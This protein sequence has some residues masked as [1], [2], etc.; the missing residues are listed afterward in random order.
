M[1]NMVVL[2]FAFAVLLSGPA[3]GQT[4]PISNPSMEA[5]SGS[6]AGWTPSDAGRTFWATTAHSGSRS[7]AVG[8]TGADSSVSWSLDR[9]QVDPGS[10]YRLSFWSKAE[11]AR[12]GGCIVSGLASANCDHLFSPVWRRYET[13]FRVP[14]TGTPVLRLGQW[15][16]TG[17]V[18]FDDVTLVRVT[19]AYRSFGAIE[20]GNGESVEGAK[21]A[22]E[23]PLWIGNAS[24]HPLVVCRAGFN[25]NRW[26]LTG[27]DRVVY[28]HA[29]AG[30]EQ[31]AGTLSVRLGYYT[32]GRCVVEASRDGVQWLLVCEIARKQTVRTALPAALF[33]AAEI[34]VRISCVNG[35]KSSGDSDPGSFQVN[36]YWYE[37]ALDRPV[38]GPV[39][40]GGTSNVELAAVSA[41][42][43]VEQPDLGQVTIG[44][45]S[46]MTFIIAN[47]GKSAVRG[48]ASLLLASDAGEP[49]HFGADFV[50]APGKTTVKVP[51]EFA[52]LHAGQFQASAVV[53]IGGIE[54]YR[55]NFPVDISV[56]EAADY[57]SR[58]S[59]TGSDDI[60][61]AP[62]PYKISRDRGIP[63]AVRPAAEISA[64]RGEYESF[65]L[66]VRPQAPLAG[67]R[68]SCAGLRGPG[69][70]RI[71]ADSVSVRKV[72][73]VRIAT[74]TDR[75]DTCG[76][77]PDPLPP[78]SGPEDLAA[79][80]NQPFWI[81]VHVPAGARSGAYSGDILLTAPGWRRV[82]PV[83]LRVYDFTLP[84]ENHLQT[85]FGLDTSM[86]RR[87]HNLRAS[88]DFAAVMARY[89]D[90]FD[91]HR[92]SPY[93]PTADTHIRVDWGLS[94]GGAG[95]AAAPEQ[96]K[97][98]FAAFDDAIS[99]ALSRHPFT[100]FRFPLEGMVNIGPFKAGTPQ[101]ET[102]LGSYLR[103]VEAHLAAK[104][105]LDKAYAYWFDEPGESD[106]GFVRTGMEYLHRYAPRLR[107]ML[108]IQPEPSLY[109][110]V[111]IWCGLLDRY[112]P[113]RVRERQRL[114]EDYWWYICNGPRAPYVG[115]YIDRPALDLRLWLWQT[116]KYDVRGILIWDT[117][118]WTS[119]ATSP[120]ARQNPWND[121]MSWG[122]GY[123]TAEWGNGDGSFL[124]PPKGASPDG[125][126]YLSGPI[127]SIRWEM[128]RDGIEDYEYLYLL[129]DRVRAARA[130][131][132]H[133]RA[134]DTAEALLTVPDT[135][136]VDL[137]RYTNDPLALMERRD[138]IARAIESLGP[139]GSR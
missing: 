125:A 84:R 52:S 70:A 17:T 105:W 111:D 30:R 20:L 31:T 15:N 117:T 53:N 126:P 37:A 11:N 120:E 98:D 21:Y 106:F 6:P 119:A 73:Y 94:G 38:D 136:S 110:S 14:E 13:T 132:P 64:A 28:R 43:P 33:P 93:D 68:L 104:G 36:G 22:F 34:Q 91:A 97:I 74:P 1:R 71:D 118:Y 77:W 56:L 86:V 60:W 2:F 7:L 88:Q 51:Y 42:F 139:A 90:D 124:Y 69:N 18:Y 115:E 131:D 129:R 134:V 35:K 63:S 25:S 19:P 114:G 113:A 67:V 59:A 133:S 3:Q 78:V 26:V 5:G 100:G 29:V 32:G 72:E 57:G 58:L 101:Y 80:Q 4:I 95:A 138:R 16:G 61:W 128:L 46:T 27:S 76:D 85:A 66:V 130:R 127:D 48:R 89:Y 109:G 79:G 107:R 55:A 83:N 116:W 23:A 10:V 45:P 41:D 62:A 87:Y 135:I 137:T 112:D 102:L 44:K 39:L 75:A 49:I 122:S 12:R 65:Q 96:V 40:R 81:T 47:P 108:T 50:A 82:V 8:P 103:Q 121:P 24:A 54:K 99:A 9:L 92:I 123:R